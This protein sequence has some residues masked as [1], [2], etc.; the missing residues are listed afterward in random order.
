MAW[1]FA[2]GI[3]LPAYTIIGFDG[4]AHTSE[5]TNGASMAVPQGIIRAVAVFAI[6]GWLML[7]AMVIVIPDINTTLNQVSNVLFWLIDQVLPNWLSFVLLVGVT[8]TQ[9]CCGMA[10]ITSASLVIYAFSRDGG[11]P[12]SEVLCSVSSVYRTPR[13]AGWLS[14][15]LAVGFILSAP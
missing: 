5:E 13:E 1:L 2:L 8:I 9:Y 7:I 12:F 11:M 10:M 14:A 15:N 4:S 6:V 3:L